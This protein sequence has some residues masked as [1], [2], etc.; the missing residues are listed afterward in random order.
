M[1]YSTC[2]RSEQG[3]EPTLRV[4]YRRGIN[5]DCKKIVQTLAYFAVA[6]SYVRRMFITLIPQCL[7]NK[8]FYGRNLFRS[9]VKVRYCVCH[10]Q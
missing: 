7:S 4:K 2:F 9:K 6:V 1:C 5:Y 3:E 8:T 10:C